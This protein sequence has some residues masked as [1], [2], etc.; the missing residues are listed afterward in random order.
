VK[1]PNACQGVTMPVALLGP[2]AAALGMKFYTGSMFPAEYR[3]SIFVARHGS[4]NRTKK[5][6]FD[7]VRVTATPDGRNARVEPFLSGLLDA[8]GEKFVGRPT[9]VLQMP[10]GSLLVSDEQNG[11]IY[12]VSYRR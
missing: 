8:A 3:D 4:W 7:V 5:T 11:A 2:H 1:K 12:R 6:G 10:D 9:D